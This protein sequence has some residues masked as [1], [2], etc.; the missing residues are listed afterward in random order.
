MKSIFEVNVS[1]EMCGSCTTTIPSLSNASYTL[2]AAG[3]GN[4][5]QQVR[6]ADQGDARNKRI[7]MLFCSL[8][9]VNDADE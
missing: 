1:A 7:R 4:G 6:K 9:K 5:V 3:Q 8:P 2:P